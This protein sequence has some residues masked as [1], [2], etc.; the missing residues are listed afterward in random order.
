[1][2]VGIVTTYDAPHLVADLNHYNATFGLPPF[3]ACGSSVTRT[4]CLR[5]VNQNGKP[6]LPDPSG[7]WG[8]LTATVVEMVHGL[9]PTCTLDV[10]EASPSASPQSQLLNWG[11]AEVTAVKRLHAKVVMNVWYSNALE[12]QAAHN[13]LFVQDNLS[14]AGV[15]LVFSARP[16][17]YGGV[18]PAGPSS[19]I[20]VGGTRLFVDRAGRWAREEAYSNTGSGCSRYWTSEAWEKPQPE[21]PRTGCGKQR[22]VVDVSAAADVLT[23]AWMWITKPSGHGWERDYDS[24][25]AG[26][27]ITAAYALG[28]LHDKA[29][30]YPAEWTYHH[31]DRRYL[32]DPV[33]GSNGSCGTRPIRCNGLRGYDLPTGLGSPN[34][35]GA[36]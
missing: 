32:H 22:A 34:G 21:W 7:V 28:G 24:L 25:V 10:V 2:T 1:V 11:K 12:T 16:G 20:V 3:P 8:G 5:K 17:G 15:A 29:Y 19:V 23:P 33:G 35:V 31:R 26:S 14:A 13:S 9:C 18:T 30:T 4:S 6:K 36:F 27:I